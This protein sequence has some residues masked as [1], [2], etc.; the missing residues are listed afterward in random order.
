M[1]AFSL[2]RVR[3]I[4]ARVNPRYIVGEGFRA[5]DV[6]E[7]SGAWRPGPRPD[8]RTGA[9]QRLYATRRNAS[10][11]T[12]IGLRH[13]TGART[14]TADWARVAQRLAADLS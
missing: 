6:L 1:E 2:D 8:L 12:L 11:T 3:E 14:S 4:L 10:G 7:Q 9:G 5:F 13:P